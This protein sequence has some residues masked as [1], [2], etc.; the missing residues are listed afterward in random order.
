MRM[1]ISKGKDEEEECVLV[2]NHFDLCT[3]EKC[4]Q[5]V[6]WGD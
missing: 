6:S 2:E 5:T 3:E 4:G 1:H